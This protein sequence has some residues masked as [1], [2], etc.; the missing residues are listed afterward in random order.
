MQYVQ[1]HRTAAAGQLGTSFSQSE[2]VTTVLMER[3]PWTLL[4]AGS[5]VVFTV[6]IGIPLGVTAATHAHGALDR[7]CRSSA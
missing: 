6:L 4:L 5:A 2:P 7:P 1:I 3:L